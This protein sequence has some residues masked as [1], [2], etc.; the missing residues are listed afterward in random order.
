MCVP[1]RL[2]EQKL[3][4]NVNAV[5]SPGVPFSAE[6]V[7]LCDEYGLYVVDEADIETHG[8]ACEPHN[9]FDLISHDLAW[10]PRYLDRVKRMYLRDRSRAGIIMWSLGNESGCGENHRQM[11]N[12]I[13]SRKADAIIHYENAH[14]EYQSRLCKDFSD[15]SDVESR[16]YASLDYLDSYLKNPENH[17]PFYYCEYVAAWS[18]GDIPLHWGKFEEFDN[19][20]GG[21]I[22]EYCDHAVNIGTPESPK[23]RYG[24][25]F[26]DHP[27]DSNFC[28]DG[29]VYP[30]RRPHTGFY[31]YK[32]AIKPFAITDFDAEKF[33]HV[34]NVTEEE[35]AEIIS[36]WT[37]I[38]IAKLV[39]GERE[40]LLNLKEENMRHRRSF[41]GRD[42]S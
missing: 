17:K 1:F 8:V 40:K 38:P 9:N 37:G 29:L 24:G 42:E 14:L 2:L 34:Q 6:F 13:R 10:A 28:V 31:E 25:D 30:N 21:C 19:Y 16:M 35:I 33:I 22:W 20:M 41:C 36:R 18:T 11:A 5:R 15:I 27:N 12:Y 26:G 4:L 23:Y 7:E 39:Q 32:E 3:A